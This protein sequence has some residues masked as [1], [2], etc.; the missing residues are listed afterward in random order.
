[1]PRALASVLIATGLLAF[2]LGGC[3]ESEQTPAAHETDTT[4]QTSSE[5]SAFEVDTYV[6]RGIVTSL[7]S[8]GNPM[9]GFNVRHE[10]IP[11][12]RAQAGK[13][14]M[15]SMTMP[16]PMGESLDLSATSVG[17]KVKLT[18]TVD[19]DT[20]AD[21]LLAYRA[22]AIEPLPADTALKFGRSSE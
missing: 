6:V 7:P 13:T 20:K 3:G 5:N 8:E 11:T 1:M 9:N 15:N 21:K 10:E 2:S 18:F 19:F 14:G 12:F 4:D 22:T 16:F 17:D